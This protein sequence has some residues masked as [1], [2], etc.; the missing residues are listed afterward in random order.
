MSR[1]R[2]AVVAAAVAVLA[3]TN[4]LVIAGISSVADGAQV[5]ALRVE[6][7]RAFYAAEAGAV[8]GVK[9]VTSGWELP[10]EGSSFA[11]G[12]SASVEFTDLPGADGVGT[13]GVEG[14]SGF[15]RRRLSL[16][17]Q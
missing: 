4:L 17:L 1:R 13:L 8:V 15:G 6:T 14:R 10:S 12:A 3:L 9:S 2:G 16:E 5:A 7:A 11:V